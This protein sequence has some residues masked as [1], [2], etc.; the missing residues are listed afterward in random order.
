MIEFPQKITAGD[1]LNLAVAPQMVNGKTY[2]S[3]KYSLTIMIRGLGAPIDV[4]ATTSSL[5][6]LVS[7]TTAQGAKLQAGIAKWVAIA[8]SDTERVTIGSGTVE[9]VEDI[10]NSS[11]FDGR[12]DARKALD[13]AEKALATFKPS[14]GMV[15]NYTIGNRQMENATIAE[16]LE[17]RNF[18]A[19]KV[20]NEQG[21]NRDL[22]VGFK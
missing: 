7:M 13:Q 10:S 8:T 19:L 17:A 3:D 6:W 21:R 11:S 14:G 5:G 15:K 2:A 4:I 1:S 16:L 18:W 20:A 22:L 9:I 12:T